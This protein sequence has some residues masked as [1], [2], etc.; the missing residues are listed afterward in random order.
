MRPVWAEKKRKSRQR[1]KNIKIL[2]LDALMEENYEPASDQRLIDE[3]V[4]DKLLLEMLCSALQELTED[5]R[6]LIDALFY[7]AKTERA[8]AAEIGVSQKTVN[9]RKNSILAKL[10]KLIE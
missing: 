7:H 9:N 8:V 10:R 3:I 6:G 4:E 2:S 1:D 5:E